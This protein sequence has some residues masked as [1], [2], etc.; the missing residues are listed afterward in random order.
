MDEQRSVY[1]RSSKS[2]VQ[3]KIRK[4]SVPSSGS[5]LKAIDGLVKFTNM[6]RLSLVHKTSRLFHV[7]LL[8][9]MTMKKRIRNGKLSDVPIIGDSQC[10]EQP[11]GSWFDDRTKGLC[12]INASLLLETFGHKYGLEPLHGS[13]SFPFNSVHPLVMNNMLI[14]RS[15]TKGPSTI[16]DESCIF[17]SHGCVPARVRGS[18]AIAGGF[19]F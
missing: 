18:L 9:Q 8:C 3:Q 7:Y 1:Q 5:L 15:G 14:L 16:S 19:S 13:I 4:L 12:V 2:K 11:N 17:S 6:S 10:E